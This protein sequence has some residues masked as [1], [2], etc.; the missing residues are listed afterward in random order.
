MKINWADNFAHHRPDGE[1]KKHF[2][3]AWRTVMFSQTKQPL[4][5]QHDR[6]RSGHQQ[7]II[8][9]RMQKRPSP[10]KMR[11]K[12]SGRMRTDHQPIEGIGRQ[13]KPEQ[14][15][16]QITEAVH[17][18][19]STNPVVIASNALKNKIITILS[20]RRWQPTPAK[21]LA[22]NY[23]IIG[24]VRRTRKSFKSY[25]ASSLRM[26]CNS[27]RRF[28]VVLGLAIFNSLS[29]SRT[30]RETINR[31]FSLSSAGTTNQGASCVLVAFRQSS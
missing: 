7:Q 12:K 13:G 22:S 2:R 27:S 5:P 8:K 25:F 26:D 16:L 23:R 24:S 30:M 1:V 28:A 19:S 18:A 4:N 3:P 29:P 20:Y 6:Q 10:M 11:M 9:V 14:P 31:A 15:V 21:I 17:N